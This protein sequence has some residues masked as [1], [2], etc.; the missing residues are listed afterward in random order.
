MGHGWAKPSVRTPRSKSGAC[1]HLKPICKGLIGNARTTYGLSITATDLLA[2]RCHSCR[3]LS[4]LLPPGRTLRAPSKPRSRRPPP[5]P[6]I[7][8]FCALSPTRVTASK[9]RDLPDPPQTPWYITRIF[10]L[11][12]E[13]WRRARKLWHG[14][15]AFLSRLRRRSAVSRCPPCQ[16]SRGCEH[17]P[18]RAASLANPDLPRLIPCVATIWARAN[19][20][21]HRCPLR[22]SCG[23]SSPCGGFDGAAR[24]DAATAKP[25]PDLSRLRRGAPCALA[26]FWIPRLS[27]L[28][29]DRSLLFHHGCLGAVAWPPLRTPSVRRIL[30]PQQQRIWLPRVRPTSSA[31]I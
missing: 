26:R 19:G 13:T 17:T 29:F 30:R 27:C 18:P 23:R 25:A 9:V 28:S 21:R 5:S 8:A 15:R 14:W 10:Q 1:V 2:P 11:L 6:N 3:L 4:P 20:L 31:P 22:R 16:H 7:L 12:G 24:P